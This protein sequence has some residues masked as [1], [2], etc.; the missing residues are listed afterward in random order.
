MRSTFLLS[1]FAIG[2]AGCHG[3]GVPPGED[4]AIEDMAMGDMAMDMGIPDDATHIVTFT[5]FAHD[6]AETLCTRYQACGKLDA[7]QMNACIEKNLRHTG[8]DQDVEIM[9]GRI[10]INEL[11]CLDAIKN[12][13]CDQSDQAAWLTRCAQFLYIPHQAN[14]ATCVAAD[15]CTSGFCQR[16]GSDA[17][18]SEQVT[19]CNGVCAAPK[20]TGTPCRLDS[21]CASD[22]RCDR[23]G[24]GTCAVRGSLNQAC[25]NPFDVGT[26]PPCQ[27]GLICPTFP[28]ASPPKCSVP[29]MQA[30]VGGDCDPIQGSS[31]P[32]P[33]C[34]AGLYCQVQYA[35]SATA[36]TGPNDCAAIIGGYCDTGS[37]FCQTP[38]GGK[39]QTKLALGAACDPNNESFFSFVDN[40]CA[41]G[42]ICAKVGA[43]TVFTCQAYGGANADC[44]GDATCKVGFYCNAGKCT[45]WDSDGQMCD[46]ANHCAGGINGTQPVCIADNPDA[47]GVATCQVM[48]N[49][50]S[51]CLPGFEDGLCSPADLPGSSQ[52]SSAGVCAP[53]CF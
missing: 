42:S 20:A 13:R 49:V 16:G 31:T 3:N 38:T 33:A 24:T 27:F 5:M 12:S 41:D 26:G 11:Q 21:D 29:V 39:C 34:A 32:T 45:A 25:E 6:Y 23:F 7:A 53:K 37:G 1:M 4:M 22:S 17:G 30:T 36:C 19:G 10:E 2:L 44:S 51:T 28:G 35:P 40:Q 46:V 47:G 52:C 18:M 14:G 43:Q 15:E 9:K 48:K 50:G 8:W